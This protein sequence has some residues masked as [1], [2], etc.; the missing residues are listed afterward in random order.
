MPEA[1]SR[2]SLVSASLAAGAAALLPRSASA[3]RRR[4][5]NVLFVLPDQ[6]R[7]ASVGC[8]GNAEVKTPHVD[9]LASEGLL[10]ENTF[11]NSPVC[12]PARAI[13]MTGQYCH[14]NGMIAND[15]RLSEQHTT[16][17]EVFRQGGY[18]TGFIGKWHLDGGRRMPGFVPP[19]D[20]R[21][22]FEF[23]AANQC[24][25]N[26]FDSQYFRDTATPIPIRRFETEVWGDLGLEFLEATKTDPRPFFLCVFSG[27]PHDPYKAPEPYERM[28]DASRLTMRPNWKAGENVPGPQQIASYY[29]ATT[30]IDDQL[31]RL[32]KGLDDLGLRED[33]IVL[34]SSDHGDMLGSQGKRLK[35]KPWEESIHVPGVLRYPRAVQAGRREDAPFSLVDFAPTLLKMC[36]LNPTRQMQ[37]VDFSRC[38]RGQKQDLPDSAFF[39]IFGPY[40]AGG[41]EAGWRGIRTSRYV[42]ARY[43]DRPWVLYDRLEDPY[44]RNN[45]ISDPAAKKIAESLDRQLAA[46]M[47]KTGDS[48]SFNWTAPL[49]DG[50]RLYNERMY[51]TVQEYLADHPNG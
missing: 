28:Y 23:W 43:T 35:R 25:H 3:Q 22:G 51:R 8:M 20:R 33:T 39:Q 32:L 49:E 12:C 34:F 38:I 46:W 10:F 44:E 14:R 9:R 31:G 24:N 30:A 1:V 17:A 5:P 19:G 13:L 16:I 47:K 15:L 11:A 21:Q 4:R 29:A 48:W 7:A 36:D 6:L 42:Y 18:R 45:L 27:P 2:R 40:A 37:G 50:G 41:V 26:H